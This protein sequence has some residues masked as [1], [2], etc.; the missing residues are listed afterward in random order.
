MNRT[1]Q[2]TSNVLEQTASTGARQKK[3][4]R[5]SYFVSA[6]KSRQKL[7][8]NHQQNTTDIVKKIYGDKKD[9]VSGQCRILVTRTFMLY[10]GSQ[11]KDLTMGLTCSLNGRNRNVLF[12]T[13]MPTAGR[14][15]SFLG[16]KAEVV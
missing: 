9:E 2:V 4:I 14:G 15:G 16:V 12:F 6:A 13:T 8:D 1:V 10:Q 3:K 11:M 5:F 7:D